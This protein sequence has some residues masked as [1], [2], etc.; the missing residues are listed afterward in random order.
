M[1]MSCSIANMNPLA[2]LSLV[3]RCAITYFRILYG[4]PDMRER[5]IPITMLTLQSR[6]SP[7]PCTGD[8]QR[9]LPE[10]TPYLPPTPP[11]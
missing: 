3:I 4:R 10:G 5:Q 8:L 11:Q 1:K 7:N 2:Y 6:R 9:Q